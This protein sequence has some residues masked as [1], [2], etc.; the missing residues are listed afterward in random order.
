MAITQTYNLDLVPNNVPLI[1]HCSQYDKT[2]RLLVFNMFADGEA[3]EVPANSTVTIRGTKMDNTG[4]E[5]SCS[6]AG[7]QVTAVLEEQMTIFAGKVNCEIRITQGVQ[8]LGTAN[9][10]L[11]VEPT[12][13]ADDVVISETDLPLLEE[14]EQNAIRAE[15]ASAQAQAL[16]PASGTTGQF[17]QKTATGTQWANAGALPSGGS[18]NQVLMK[19]SSTNYDA[20]WKTIYQIPTGGTTGQA[21]TKSSSSNYATTWRTLVPSGGTTGQA[22]IKNSSTAYDSSWRDIFPSGGTD[23]QFL[24]K[25]S[26]GTA[27]ADASGGVPAG[28]AAGQ[29][30]VKQSSTDGDATW[31]NLESGNVT[32]DNESSDLTATNVKAAIDEVATMAGGLNWPVQSWPGD[33][34]NITE[35]G[36]YTC[37]ANTQHVPTG[38]GN[39]TIVLHFNGTYANTPTNSRSVQLAFIN[40]ATSAIFWRVR[41]GS[42]G[43][44]NWRSVAGS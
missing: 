1:V 8:I 21:L 26:S 9:F 3:Y 28:G 13:L 35:T 14:A 43:W 41:Q 40:S 12:S 24:Q 29:T 38:G 30:L 27:W 25:T 34:N 2:S 44:G 10:I 37:T 18:S 11:E 15:Q 32:Y 6:Y 42:S 20:S 16:I 22:L 5:Y 19:N 36:G 31:Q 23:G 17:L 7:T 4:F 39:Y 33:L